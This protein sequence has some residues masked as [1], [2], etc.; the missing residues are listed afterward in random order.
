MPDP[1]DTVIAHVRKLERQL[2]RG[3]AGQGRAVGCDG[4]KHRTPAV[5][6]RLG[7]GFIIVRDNINDLH[8]VFHFFLVF[9]GDLPGVVEL[10]LGRQKLINIDT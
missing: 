4:Q 1:V 8:P 10:F 3:V 2:A 5:H 9:R 7:P 6:A